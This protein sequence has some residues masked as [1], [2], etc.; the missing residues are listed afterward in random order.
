[1]RTFFLLVLAAVALAG[2]AK[3][4]GPP[5]PAFPVLGYDFEVRRPGGGHTKGQA[6][7]FSVQDGT[8]KV[9]LKDGRLTVNSMSYG[10]VADGAKI[11]VEESGKVIVNG[12]TRS[13]E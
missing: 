11:I 1:M 13:P 3:R 9:E 6:A 7:T 4:K 5:S 12:E 10:K 2:C 8:N